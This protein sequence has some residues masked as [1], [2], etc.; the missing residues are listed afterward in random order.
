MNASSKGD[1]TSQQQQLVDFYKTLYSQRVEGQPSLQ[2][3]HNL[4]FLREQ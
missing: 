2:K 4:H 3:T 1:D